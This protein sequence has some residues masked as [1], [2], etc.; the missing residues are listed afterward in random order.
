M[1]N[2]FDST[3][4]NAVSLNDVL[5]SLT[6]PAASAEPWAQQAVAE[7]SIVKQWLN[8]VP[9]P[10]TRSVITMMRLVSAV[11]AAIK[12]NASYPITE[13]ATIKESLQVARGAEQTKYLARPST[14]EE[15]QRF[16]AHLREHEW[17]AGNYCDA[18][19]CYE[20]QLIQDLYDGWLRSPLSAPQPDSGR[21]DSALPDGVHIQSYRVGDDQIIPTT[22]ERVRQLGGI[23]KWAV[24]NA[25]NCLNKSGEWEWE[26]MPSSRD[27]EFLARCRFDSLN[28][29]IDAALA[30][31]GE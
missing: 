19:H 26:P 15:R 16:E 13:S 23:E 7:L 25:G 2:Q 30:A 18:K 14:P 3:A 8:D 27:D 6:Q 20:L 29:A 31:K 11:I 9:E 24:R 21:S 17:S 10:G 22:V 5:G 1:S 12:S 28:E 4:K